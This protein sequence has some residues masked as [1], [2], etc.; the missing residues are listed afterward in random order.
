MKVRED[1]YDVESWLI[2]LKDAQL[3]HI[4][5]VREPIYEKLMTFFPTSGKFWKAYIEHESKYRNYE[6]VEKLFQRSLMKVLSIDLWKT[7]LQYVKETK[8][9]LPTYKEKMAQAYDFAL[10]KMGMDIASYSI[11]DDYV[12]FLKG[13]DAVGSYAEN[14]KI[15]AIRKMYQRGIINPMSG[16][17]TLW[18]D[19]VAFEQSINP[20]IAEKMTSEKS[21]DYMNARRVTKEYEA[22]TR[23]LNKGAA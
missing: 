21:R 22:C 20:I 17:E 11:W 7:Y 15:T 19:Y 18:K 8:A 23:G 9:K 6:K 4:E 16:I 5:E 10:D 3:R 12:K 14:Q 13:V 1:P 2:I